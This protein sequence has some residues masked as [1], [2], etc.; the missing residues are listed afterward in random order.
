MWF[1]DVVII[2]CLLGVI[3]NLYEIKVLLKD[4]TEKGKVARHDFKRNWNGS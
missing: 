4:K 1:F 3:G 2:L